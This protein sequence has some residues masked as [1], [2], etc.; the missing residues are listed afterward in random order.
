M[1]VNANASGGEGMRKG[2]RKRTGVDS[3]LQSRSLVRYQVDG[4]H[5]CH[6]VAVGSSRR[7]PMHLSIKRLA[8][9][10]KRIFCG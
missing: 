5:L 9:K 1:S 10:A 2:L 7:F 3:Y 4:G 6:A 8:N